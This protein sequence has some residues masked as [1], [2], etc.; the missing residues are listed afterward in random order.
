M[1]EATLMVPFSFPNETI[2]SEDVGVRAYNCLIRC[3]IRNTQALID[4]FDKVDK[5]NV[6]GCGSGT[7]RALY[8]YL[9]NKQLDYIEKRDG[10]SR[11][12]AEEKFLLSICKA[13]DPNF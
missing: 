13:N 8:E 5:G 1:K 10:I 4:N 12:M 11:D 3:N 9:I 7:K 6:R 2:D